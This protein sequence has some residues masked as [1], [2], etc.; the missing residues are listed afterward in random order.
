MGYLKRLCGAGSV[1]LLVCV[2]LQSI[3]LTAGAQAP[4]DIPEVLTPSLEA[5]PEPSI[6]VP[7]ETPSAKATAANATNSTALS[8]QQNSI[9]LEKLVSGI[10][11]LTVV[12]LVPLLV[13]IAVLFYT[14]FRTEQ[15]GELLSG[16]EENAAESARVVRRP[17]RTRHWRKRHIKR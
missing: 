10:P 5:P 17:L 11:V 4:S 6:Y 14:L 13:V 7:T 2:L 16:E 8:A 3:V 9:S 12:L 1:C 15:E